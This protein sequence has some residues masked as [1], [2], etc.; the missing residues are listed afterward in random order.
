MRVSVCARKNSVCARTLCVC[1]QELLCAFVCVRVCARAPARV[2][3]RVLTELG[4]AL[5][6]GLE[7]ITAWSVSGQL[8]L[9][10]W[11][12]K[13]PLLFLCLHFL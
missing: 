6:F 12:L 1:V 13:K 8:W 4:V 11:L 9:L 3:T 10:L 7:A 2:G 5:G